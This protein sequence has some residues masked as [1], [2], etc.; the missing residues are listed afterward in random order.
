MKALTCVLAAMFAWLAGSAVLAAPPA[1]DDMQDFVFLGEARPV[2]V[3][4]HVRVDGRVLHAA[5]DDCIGYLFQHLDVNKDGFLS[6][7]EVERAPTA[8]QILGNGQPRGFDG[9][10]RG[11]TAPVGTTMEA[12]D[13]DRDGKVTR[14][15]LA[16]YYR[17]TG[18]VPFRFNFA[19][20]Q[21]NPL[22]AAAAIFGGGRTEPSVEAVS[23]AIFDLLDT[24]KDGKLSK[25]EL[26]AAVNVLLRQDDDEDEIVTAQEVAPE[27][28]AN[29]AMF[30]GMM[31]MGRPARFDPN[32]SNSMLV[33]VLKPGEVP[34]DLARRLLERYARGKAAEDRKLG[35]KELGLDEL[36][37][38]RLDLNKDG[39]LDSAELGG[40]TKRTPD[41]E[42]VVRL[43]KTSEPR[44]EVVSSD[45][46]SP[47]A[48]KLLL[49]DSLALLDLGVTRAELRNNNQNVT[50]LIGAARQQYLDQFRLAD[51]DG[52][53][54]LDA[55]E[56]QGSRQLRG[57]I[58]TVDRDGDGKIT[59]AELLAYIG[60][61]QQLHKLVASGC[62]TLDLSDQSRGLFDLLD[63]NRDGRLSMREMRGASKLLAQLDRVR[64]GHL[65]RDDVPKT[66]RLEV[67]RTGSNL[68][69]TGGIAA[70]LSLYQS[71]YGASGPDQATTGPLWFRKMDRN[72]DGDV[73]RKEF[74]FGEELFRQID[75]DSD[76]LISVE[77][78]EKAK[79]L[80]DRR[81][82]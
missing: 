24:D 17:K 51:K 67:R 14:A 15:E 16:A 4:L 46:R 79:G 77:E 82:P 59:Q 41:L 18:F 69:A 10:R 78:A 7:A 1:A 9:G 75:A 73:S 3:R 66:Y 22:G 40:F 53:G 5:W 31:A 26:A 54:V 58:K 63:V 43:G 28:S 13:A 12:V 65:T 47:L 30:A 34:L 71:P 35:R 6:K 37:F 76:G 70:I 64:K 81:S 29:V 33:P 44:L 57:L 62:V 80:L 11:T 38:N 72:R 74:L 48:D 49:K 50:D 52:N 25:Q 68:G 55:D 45:G 36:T 60:H 8:E 61:L 21:P 32:A 19:T 27:T 2:L 39:V 20:G 56:L 42:L 23:K